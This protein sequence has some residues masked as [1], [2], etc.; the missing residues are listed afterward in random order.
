MG[1]RAQRRRALRR[2]RA[3]RAAETVRDA[4]GRDD[5]TITLRDDRRH[6]GMRTELSENAI[7]LYFPDWEKW[8]EQ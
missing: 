5:D 2:P 6:A 1:N 8:Q 3:G 7:Y 4:E